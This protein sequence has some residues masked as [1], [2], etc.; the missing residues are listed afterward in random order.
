M[1]KKR[2][3]IRKRKY[4][5]KIKQEE[6]YQTRWTLQTYI[7]VL[8]VVIALLII[9]LWGVPKFNYYPGEPKIPSL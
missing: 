6:I 7:V 4:P 1:P 3:K 2:P 9:L 5:K 8:I